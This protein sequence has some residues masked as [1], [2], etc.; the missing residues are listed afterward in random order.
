[1]AASPTSAASHSVT[2]V[3]HFR[4]MSWGLN[5]ERIAE[6]YCD[7]SWLTIPDMLKPLQLAQWSLGEITE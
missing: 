2:K 1:M 6:R 5:L 4:F 3:G 7:V